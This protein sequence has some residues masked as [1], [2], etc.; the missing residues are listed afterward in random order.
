MSRVHVEQSL[1]KTQRTK[2]AFEGVKKYFTSLIKPETNLV[3]PRQMAKVNCDN[4]NEFG[5]FLNESR[6]FFV[7]VTFQR[8]MLSKPLL[9]YYMKHN[10]LLMWTYCP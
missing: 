5:V 10:E 6:L 4:D 1:L 8:G 9:N 2:L 7:T 3:C